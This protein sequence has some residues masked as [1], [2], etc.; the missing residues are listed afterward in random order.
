MTDDPPKGRR[1]RRLCKRCDAVLRPGQDLCSCGLWNFATVAGADDTVL[2]SEVEDAMHERYKTGPWD[3]C[4]GGGVVKTSVTLIGGEPG[5]GK[6]TLSLQ[7]ADRLAREGEV[8]YV[9]AEE[10][11]PAIKSRALRLELSNTRSVRMVPALGAA[12]DL[13]PMFTRYRPRA[14]VLDSLAGLFG[15][16]IDEA[17]EAA[18]RVKAYAVDLKAPVLIVNH[19]TKDGDFAGLKALEHAVDTTISFFS[20]GAVVKDGDKVLREERVMTTHKNRYGAAHVEVFLWM[21]EK[22]LVKK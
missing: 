22:G 5:A 18:R 13:G 20:T 14:I 3:E 2:L 10:D 7:I 4:F 9:A 16:D 12:V 8:L 6:S 15:D 11:L 21:T 19:V 17:A 1:P